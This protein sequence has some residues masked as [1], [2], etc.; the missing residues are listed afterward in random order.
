MSSPGITR[1][2]TTPPPVRQGDYA[3]STYVIH[4]VDQNGEPV[5]GCVINF[6]TDETC[7][8]VVADET[9]TA[10]FKGAPFA[11]LQVIRVP[12]G[13]EFDTAQEYTPTKPEA[14]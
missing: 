3:L 10:V 11:Y 8:P 12:D 1:T 6:C 13:Y 9:G 2:E 4:F 14:R 5:P 7:V